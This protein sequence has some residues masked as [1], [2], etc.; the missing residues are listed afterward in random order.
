MLK[1]KNYTWSKMRLD[2]L[3]IGN[4]LHYIGPS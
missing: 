1:H 2:I 4:L 3:D